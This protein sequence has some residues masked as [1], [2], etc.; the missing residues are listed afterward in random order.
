MVPHLEPNHSATTVVAAGS[1]NFTY[2]KDKPQRLTLLTIGNPSPNPS[3]SHLYHPAELEEVGN[4][5]VRTKSGRVAPNTVQN[6]SHD[7][8]P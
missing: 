2:F 5:H 1:L 7:L 3:P 8:K 4:D 6:V